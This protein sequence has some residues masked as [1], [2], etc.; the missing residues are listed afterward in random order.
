MPAGSDA[1]DAPPT[2]QEDLA[3]ADRA[4]TAL[5][6]RVERRR[7]GKAVTL[8]SGFP[9]GT[10]LD[11]VATAL[12]RDLAVGG[13]AKHDHVELQGDQTARLGPALARLGFAPARKG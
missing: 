7:Y 2:W 4:R 9:A 12:K 6:V 1:D 5:L 13:S 3:A 8:V 11:A 10:D